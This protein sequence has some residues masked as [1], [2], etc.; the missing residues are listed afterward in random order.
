[1]Q[2]NNSS[3]VI[4]AFKVESELANSLRSA[5]DDRH[6]PP[7]LHRSI[8][9]VAERPFCHLTHPKRLRDSRA[10]KKIEPPT[11]DG[12]MFRAYVGIT[13]S[14]LVLL[15]RTER[16][17]KDTGPPRGKKGYAMRLWHSIYGLLVA[18]LSFGTLSCGDGKDRQAVYPVRGQV[19]VQGKP[20]AGALVMFHPLN[21]ADSQTERPHGQADQD[22]VFVL[23][24]YGAHDGAPP[25]STS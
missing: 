15:C 4:V 10:R 14:Y 8:A 6:R 3:S 19:F 23:S 22:G 1:M 20:A 21:D 13:L 17:Q 16:W 24:T 25:A 12:S 18:L 7:S 5:R 2:N 11:L 9:G